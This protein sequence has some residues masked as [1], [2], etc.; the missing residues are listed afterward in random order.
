MIRLTNI[1]NEQKADKLNIL[2][3]SDQGD[4][5]HQG[6]ARKLIANDIVTGTVE[7]YR[8]GDDSS[9]LTNLIYYN[10]SSEYDLVVVYCSGLYDE[11]ARTVIENLEKIINICNR[12]NIPVVFITIPTTRFIDDPS[13][14]GDKTNFDYIAKVNNWIRKSDATYVVDLYTIDDDVYF[15]PD[16]TTL[17]KQG[18]NVIYKRLLD[19]IGNLDPDLDID[20][21][22]KKANS[23]DGVLFKGSI[24][25][26]KALQNKLIALG[27]KIDE[28]EISQ[29]RYGLSTKK[30]VRD[31]QL[32]TGLIATGKVDSKTLKKIQ[33]A[34]IPISATS[35]VKV[36]LSN[37]ENT[38]AMEVMSFLIDK[39]LSVA[40]AA[41]I[42]G[43]MKIESNFKT[44]ILGDHGTSIGLCQ[45]HL[46][47]KDR[48]FSWTESE[49]FEPLSVE[50]QLE[51]LWWE[52][53][54]S[55]KRLVYE[56]E[57][58]EDPREAA[59]QFAAQFERPAHIAPE[60]MEYAQ[61]YFDEYNDSGAIGTLKSIWNGIK[62]VGT[63]AGAAWS[64]GD[65][66]ITNKRNGKLSNSELVDIGNGKRLAPSAARDFLEMKAAAKAAGVDIIV[67]GGY[68]DLATQNAIFD[69]DRYKRTGE[70]MKINAKNVPAAYPGTSNHGIGK[71][72][73][74]D[75][76]AGRKWIKANG[77]KYGWYWGEVPSEPWHFT[78]RR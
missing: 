52:L 45:W 53:N 64:G 15:N 25:N 24:N 71:A 41:G 47:R 63:L 42:A 7:S 76:T 23:E 35:K 1:L 28:M 44:S 61:Q 50:G 18:S 75:N 21:E 72:M 19:I 46:E 39:G 66:K 38:N 13:K 20:S 49:G 26:L 4:E 5:K 73:D 12:Y 6:Y 65:E 31:F 10:I 33:A 9:E 37:G 78:Y 62:T 59:K 51:Y 2:F 40:G 55:F 16:G 69:W 32:K 56:L 74:I 22:K 77:E 29:K 54:H 14:F 48:L 36:Q 17:N 60:R 34:V 70:K 68:R 3:V 58:I 11:N 27:Y 57:S 8:S 43:N 30:A 67:G